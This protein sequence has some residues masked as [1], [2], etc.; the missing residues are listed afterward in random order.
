MVPDRVCGE[1][2][3]D[4]KRCSNIIDMCIQSDDSI[5]V[6]CDYHKEFKYEKSCILGFG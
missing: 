2:F 1:P 3:K 5:T 4:A 6:L